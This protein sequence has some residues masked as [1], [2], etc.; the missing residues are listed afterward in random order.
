MLGRATAAAT[1]SAF[2]LTLATGPGHPLAALLAGKAA[3]R[4]PAPDVAGVDD[5][6]DNAQ[7]HD[8][9]A[10]ES[11]RGDDAVHHSAQN[12]GGRGRCRSGDRC[13]LR[14]E[15]RHHGDGKPHHQG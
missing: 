10:W 9:Y 3:Y 15:R 7:H 5:G 8:G 11:D 4:V 13:S 12:L 14:H 2:H 1:E 6:A